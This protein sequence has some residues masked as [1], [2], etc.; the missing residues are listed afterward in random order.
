MTW[1][2]TIFRFLNYFC[3][4]KKHKSYYIILYNLHKN[5]HAITVYKHL[6][7][8]NA[9]NMLLDVS[10]LQFP[11][12]DFSCLHFEVPYLTHRHLSLK[13]KMCTNFFY[14]DKCLC[15]DPKKLI[16]FALYAFLKMLI[17]MF[18]SK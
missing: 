7:A 8:Y 6:N 5:Q 10:F 13:K 14:R 4:L 18:Y 2:C 12:F 1:A 17:I 11:S 16:F 9:K 3:S 15:M